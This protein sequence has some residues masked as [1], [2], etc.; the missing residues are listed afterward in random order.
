MNWLEK[1]HPVTRNSPGLEWKIFKK[2]H[3][4]GVGGI[5]LLLAIGLGNRWL[6]SNLN[7][8]H[9]QQWITKVDAVLWGVLFTF[10]S[11]MVALI[12]GC[13]LVIVMKGPQYRADSYI[14]SDVDEPIK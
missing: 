13:V 10:L 14:M 2:L 12:V 6:N 11:L 4:I 8:I 3:L 1:Q 9:Y 7:L 5:G